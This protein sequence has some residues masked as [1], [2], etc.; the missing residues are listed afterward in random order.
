MNNKEE[1]MLASLDRVMRT[2]RR[3][4]AG[5]Q[6][7][8]RG[9]YRLLKIISEQPN[10]PT[11]VIADRLGMRTSSLNERLV[12]MEAE[13]VITRE[14]DEKDQRVFVVNI[15]P[16]GEAVLEALRGERQKMGRV[17]EDILTEAEIDTLT[18]LADKLSSGLKNLGE[19][20]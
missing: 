11:R 15:S 2:L 19:T 6:K 8:G 4:P 7:L 16:A 20:P 5:K 12:R 3:R 14:R 17:I 9:G 13:G 1:M 18:E 10:T